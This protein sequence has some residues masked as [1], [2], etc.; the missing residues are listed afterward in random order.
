MERSIFKASDPSDQPLADA[1]SRSVTE[2]LDFIR[3][4][5]VKAERARIR[6]E[7]LESFYLAF[8]DDGHETRHLVEALRRICPEEG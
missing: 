4:E 7:L 5:A 8:G 3:A 1:M 2:H 6:R